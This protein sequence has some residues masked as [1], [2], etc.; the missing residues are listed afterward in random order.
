M[1]K[2]GPVC[3]QWSKGRT[4]FFLESKMG[5]Q[6]LVQFLIMLIGIVNFPKTF[7]NATYLSSSTCFV[8]FSI[9]NLPSIIYQYYIKLT[10]CHTIVRWCTGV[11]CGKIIIWQSSFSNKLDCH[12][13]FLPQ[14]TPVHHLTIVWQLV[15]FY[16]PLLK[17]PMSRNIQVHQVLQSIHDQSHILHSYDV[18]RSDDVHH[19][20]NVSYVICYVMRLLTPSHAHPGI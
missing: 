12:I 7:A 3:S 15:S 10:D 18:W 1:V 8:D 4:R 17:L 11:H 16:L 6:N 20:W 5:V 9:M 13:I 14:C 2:G 19:H